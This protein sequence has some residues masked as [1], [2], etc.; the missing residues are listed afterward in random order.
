[1]KKEFAGD[2]GDIPILP[3]VANHIPCTK[4]VIL[5]YF[6]GIATS[7]GY[8]VESSIDRSFISIRTLSR[9]E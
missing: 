2:I 9:L 7:S 4:T 6:A 1:V 8:F 3:T 5:P